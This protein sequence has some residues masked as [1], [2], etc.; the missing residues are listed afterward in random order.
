MNLRGRL[1][2]EPE[3][4]AS[5]VGTV[6]E[7]LTASWKKCWLGKV[8]IRSAQVSRKSILFD[9]PRSTHVQTTRLHFSIDDTNI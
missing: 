6:E 5:K 9:L 3:E 8:K 2:M 4:P 7:T 1:R